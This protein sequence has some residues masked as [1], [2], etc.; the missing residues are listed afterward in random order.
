MKDK[1][2]EIREAIDAGNR[3]LSALEEAA[4][5]LQAARGLGLWDM[6]GGGFL[7]SLL[8]H[9]K[10]DDAQQAMNRAEQEL[11]A[12][13]GSWRMCRCMRTFS[14]A[15]TAS[16]VSLTP[17]ATISLWTGWSSLRSSR[18]RTGWRRPGN[19]SGKPCSSCNFCR[20]REL[21]PILHFTARREAP[22]PGS[23]PSLQ[24]PHH[25]QAPIP[26]K[27][28]MGAYFGGKGHPSL[29]LSQIL[30]FYRQYIAFLK[31]NPPQPHKSPAAVPGRHRRSAPGKLSCWCRGSR[32][33]PSPAGGSALPGPA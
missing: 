25:R 33:L 20:A 11:R 16:P 27:Q 19:G 26:R 1:N 12:L 10:M 22:A 6:L 2:T 32:C 17:S 13:A 23:R 5:H 30:P 15:L 3:A 9:S 18:P 21:A 7:S 28:G 14:C 8:K 4:R 29:P 31:S 24:I